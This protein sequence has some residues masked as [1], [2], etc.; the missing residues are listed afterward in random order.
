MKSFT[1]VIPVGQGFITIPVFC[2]F[3]SKGYNLEVSIN[4]LLDT[5]SKQSK[6]S[7]DIADTFGIP[8]RRR[9]DKGEKKVAM[10]ILTLNLPSEITFEDIYVL[11]DEE[12]HLGYDFVIGMD[13]L[14][15][16]DAVISARGGEIWFTF[17]GPE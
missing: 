11:E 12:E 9:Y 4:A 10:R 8:F 13:I 2:C 5:T 16:G 1:K 17:Y 6:I 14:K 15:Q 3:R 7:K